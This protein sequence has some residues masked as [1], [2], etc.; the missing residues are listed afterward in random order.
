MHTDPYRPLFH[1]TANANWAGAP[2]GLYQARGWYHLFFL[3]NPF[4]AMPGPM[5]WGHARS[6]NLLHWEQLPL[7]LYPE[8]AYESGAGGGCFGGYAFNGPQGLTIVYAARTEEQLK[9]VTTLCLAHS[10]DE[11]AFRKD[12][13]NPLSLESGALS[14][15]TGG[16]GVWQ[17]GDRWYMVVPVRGS[18]GPRIDWYISADRSAWIYKGIFYQAAQTP[19]EIL[20]SVDCFTLENRQ[21]LLISAVQHTAAYVYA[22]VGTVDY[23]RGGFSIRTIARLDHGPHYAAAQSLS[24]SR[25]RRIVIGTIQ[26]NR[27]LGRA[28]Q[29]YGWSGAMTLPREITLLHDDTLAYTPMRELLCL[30]RKLYLFGPLVIPAAGERGEQRCAQLI[31]GAFDLSLHCAMGTGAVQLIIH[32]GSTD[33]L[34]LRIDPGLNQ[35]AV[36]VC[37]CGHGSELIQIAAGKAAIG[38]LCDMRI[39]MDQSVVE[40]SA[41][42]GRLFFTLQ[43]FPQAIV[44]PVLTVKNEGVDPVEIR[45]ECWTLG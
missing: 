2:C 10:R 27:T 20:V 42:K 5:H 25:G 35:I 13:K 1:Y 31:N 16:P 8:A 11:I 33:R 19:D 37:G 45:G 26:T 39:I 14:T 41:D 21:V 12:T 22:L 17:Y 24:D 28:M 30:R 34:V 18:D 4:D 23:G 44:A 9:P 43:I 7:A 38:A 15:I 3:H 6:T 29:R 36:L 32:F 40:I